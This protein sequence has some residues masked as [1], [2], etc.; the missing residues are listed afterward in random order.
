MLQPPAR[1]IARLDVK[2][3]NVV[4]GIQ[5]E[6]LRIV[7]QP[8]DLARR[9]Y[10]QGIDE[11]LFLDIVAS[12]YQRSSMFD[13][14]RATASDVFVPIT[15]GGGLRTLDD[16]VDALRSGADKVA[17]NTAAIARPPF[18]TEMARAFG[19]QCV[20]LSV[21]AKRKKGGG[22]SWE[23][24]TDNG[25]ERTGIDVLKWVVEAESLGAGE[26]LLTSVDQEGSAGGMDLDLLTAVHELVRIPIIASGGVGKPGDVGDVLVRNVAEAVAC[27]HVLHYGASDVSAIK[28]HLV[29]EGIPVRHAPTSDEFPGILPP[30]GKPTNSAS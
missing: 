22:A 9:Y 28:A 20:V 26:L 6:G 23:A 15:V 2:G 21:E 29:K 4:K 12:L 8:A 19:S 7:G 10:R 27:A 18:L 30:G 25:R 3:P 16:V 1:L 5:L 24:L 17:I 14:V 11:I 13:I